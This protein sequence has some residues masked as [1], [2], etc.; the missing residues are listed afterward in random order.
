MNLASSLDGRLLFAVPKKGRLNKAVLGLLEGAGIQFKPE[1]RLD[2][3]LVKHLPLALIF[4]RASEIPTF[5]ADGNVDIG[6]T[7]WD[8]VQEHDAGAA[9]AGVGQNQIAGS[10]K[11]LDLEFGYCKLQVQVPQRGPYIA[12]KDVVGKTVATSFPL[13]TAQY[14]AQLE[15]ELGA[16]E[17]GTTEII[18]LSGSVEAA[19]ALGVA[20]AIV[21]LVESGETMQAAGLK[22][23]DTV[24]ESQAVLIRSRNPSNPELVDKIARRIE[25]K[26]A[27]NRHVLCQYNIPRAKLADA[28]KITPGMRAPTITALE[29][30]GW[31]A[32]SAMVAKREVAGVM[33]DLVKAGAQDILILNFQNSRSGH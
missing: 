16:S 8:M 25:G 22:A 13:L 15:K 33:D 10:E 11:L 14:F 30:D 4:L 6:I 1:H 26:I 32:V 17:L 24:L 5:V 31:F 3:A 19:C 28:T 2:I 12:P 7:G 23:I 21:D 18:E 20:D 9:T 29:E 27:A